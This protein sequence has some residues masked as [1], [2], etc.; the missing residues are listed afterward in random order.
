MK[1]KNIFKLF[2]SELNLYRAL[3]ADPRTPTSGKLILW[4][5]IAYIFMPFDIIPDFIPVLGQL[6]EIILIPIL[7]IIALRFIPK[8]LVKEHRS[9]LKVTETN[10]K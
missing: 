1:A 4:L 7:I 5:I 10:S 3:I 8:D 6:D 9:T 2:K